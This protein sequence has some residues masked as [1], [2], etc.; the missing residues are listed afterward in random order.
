MSFHALQ[1]PGYEKHFYGWS[2]VI[3]ALHKIIYLR[4]KMK[5]WH[6]FLPFNEITGELFPTM[7]N[8]NSFVASALFKYSMVGQVNITVN[9]NFHCWV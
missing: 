1:R 7:K 2:V 3:E 5:E 6:I 4:R 9:P 8:L